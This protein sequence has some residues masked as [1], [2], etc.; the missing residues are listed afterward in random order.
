MKL[1]RLVP[2]SIALVHVAAC[3]RMGFDTQPT[4]GE[5]PDAG[6]AADAL[7]DAP[8][9]RARIGPCQAA[10]PIPDPVIATS[11]F[12]E[13]PAYGAAT[14]EPGVTIEARTTPAGAPLATATTAADGTYTLPVAT[15]GEPMPVYFAARK[16]GMATSVFVP[17]GP[18]DGDLIGLYSPIL[19]PSSLDSLYISAGEYRKSADGTL[20]VLIT[21]CSGA[22]VANASI[23]ISPPP[24]R[25]VYVDDTGRLKTSLVQTSAKGLVYALGLAPGTVS[26]T[27]TK[28]GATF[29]THELD[30]LA[31]DYMMETRLRVVK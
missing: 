28:A 7:A 12:V 13:L 29:L 5:L 30:I 1:T 24:P 8:G 6:F 4:G 31:G 18:L 9:V 25:V 14:P 11:T 22:P 27:A 10:V 20:L 15:S 17:D 21:D 19:T 3:G 26:L 2:W 16:Q 23:S